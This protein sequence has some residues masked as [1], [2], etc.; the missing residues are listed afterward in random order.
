MQNHS[1]IF[2]IYKIKNTEQQQQHVLRE[3]FFL[4]IISIEKNFI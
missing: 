3:N 1:S 2:R 4:K